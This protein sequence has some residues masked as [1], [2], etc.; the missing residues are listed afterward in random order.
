MSKRI[1]IQF[2]WLLVLFFTLGILFVKPCLSATLL[3]LEDYNS[4]TPGDLVPEWANDPSVC[5]PEVPV[6]VFFQDNEVLEGAGA[7]RVNSDSCHV[8][9]FPQTTGLIQV[10][11]FMRPRAGSDTNNGLTVLG[12]PNTGTFAPIAQSYPSNAWMGPH[13]PHEPNYLLPYFEDWY[14][15]IVRINTVTNRYDLYLGRLGELLVQVEDEQTWGANIS[16]GLDGIA[17]QSGRGARGTDSYFD[18]LRIDLLDANPGTGDIPDIDPLCV[19]GN[20]WCAAPEPKEVAIDIKPQS[21]PNPLNVRSKGV[22]PVAILGTADF[23]ATS[24][25]PASI[26][27]EGIAPIRSNVE[28]V[29]M[30]VLDPE[31]DCDC[32]EESGDGFDDLTLKFDP[33]A[34][35]GALGDVNDG[36]ELVL[37]LTGET[38]DGTPIEGMDCV[39]LLKKGKKK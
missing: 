13:L 7:A 16:D 29:S 15:I 5:T 6:A 33:Q 20:T 38:S 18:A 12:R 26:R 31:D 32:T 25:D 3:L 1:S 28:D 27:L 30:P 4:G 36:E 2:T 35:V 8:R 19:V 37:T 23:D 34:I 9:R 21:C 39:V 14:E 11:I 10:E 24:I 22:L 17:L